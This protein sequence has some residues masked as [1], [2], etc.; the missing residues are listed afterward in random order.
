LSRRNL[1]KYLADDPFAEMEWKSRELIEYWVLRILVR[2]G[3]YKALI[4]GD[5][6]G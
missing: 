3:G 1:N 2:F 4:R 6:G 5:G